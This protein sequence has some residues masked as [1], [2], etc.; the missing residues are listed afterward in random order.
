VIR[1]LSFHA[2][3]AAIAAVTLTF[4]GCSKTDSATP[5]AT[6]TLTPSRTRVALGSPVEFTYQFVVAPGAKIPAGY[7]VFVHMRDAQ[8][9]Q[10]PWND[11]HAPV[12]STDQWQAGQTIT[13]TRTLFTPVMPYLG[14]VSV[15][16]GLYKDN[17]RVALAGP[18]PADRGAQRREYKVATLQLVPN[19]ENIFLSYKG[20]WNPDEVSPSN[21]GVGWRWTQK[22]AVITFPNPKRDATLYLEFDARPD[23]F[24]GHPQQV[25]VYSNGQPVDSFVADA[26]ATQLKKVGITAA[27]LGTADLAEVRIDVDKSFVPAQIPGGGRDTRELGIR[28]YHAFVQAR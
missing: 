18:N 22:S 14:E 4:A 12:P 6:V 9:N 26:P 16:L 23:L 2:R 27:Q 8:G 3:L 25:T 7:T 28:V 17:D 21:P 11:D 5:L 19:S 10:L 15:E 24:P 13:Y 20:G 1:R